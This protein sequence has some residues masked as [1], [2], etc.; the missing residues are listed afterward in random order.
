VRVRVRVRA[1]AYAFARAHV[2]VALRGVALRGVCATD[3]LAALWLRT[4][5]YTEPT[6]SGVLGGT[7]T[8]AD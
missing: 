2:R 8:F 1:C 5:S 6:R 7:H 3:E 4:E